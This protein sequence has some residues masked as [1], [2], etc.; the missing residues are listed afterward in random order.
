MTRP[1]PVPGLNRDLCPP[2]EAPDQVRGGVEGP[3]R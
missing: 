2:P 1:N 3:A